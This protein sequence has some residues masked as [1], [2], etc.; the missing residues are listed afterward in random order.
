[1]IVGSRNNRRVRDLYGKRSSAATAFA[2]DRIRKSGL[3]P[4]VRDVYLYGSCARQEQTYESD[5]DLLI[6]LDAAFGD[7]PERSGLISG[8]KQELSGAD[9]ILPQTELKFVIGKDWKNS[10]SLF[11]TNIRREGISIW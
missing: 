3:A 8:L 10:S 6:E 7:H 9:E 11:F 4:Y 2:L 5:V 1:M